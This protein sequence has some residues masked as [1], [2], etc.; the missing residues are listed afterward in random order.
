MSLY[1]SFYVGSIF[2]LELIILMP[3]IK[4]VF[5]WVNWTEERIYPSSRRLPAAYQEVEWVWSSGSQYINTNFIP[6]VNTKIETDISWWDQ[7]SDWLVFFWVTSNDSS[8]D[9]IIARL[10]QTNKTNYNPW[11]CN[12]SYSESQNTITADQF[13][14]IVLQKNWWTI[15]WNAYTITTTW[16]PYQSQIYIF[17]WNN[18]WSAWRHSKCKVKT[19]KMRDGWEL[20]RNFIP[21]YRKSDW[22]IWLYDL[23]WWQLYTNSWSGTFTKWSDV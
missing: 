23:V 18:G 19:F 13:N 20:I 2:I 16:T 5:T 10:Y 15:N 14:N 22:V 21:C 8:W 6:S 3:K 1:S 4:E 7:S 12:S 17:C 11:F 9:W